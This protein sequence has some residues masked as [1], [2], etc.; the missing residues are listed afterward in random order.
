M[1]I[2]LTLD[3]NKKP[4]H[5]GTPFCFR[6][7]RLVTDSNAIVVIIQYRLGVF[8]FSWTLD[9]TIPSNVGLWDQVMALK[10]N[11]ENIAA[12]GGDPNQVINSF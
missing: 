12:F 3:R 6:P 5:T 11:R 8:G 2:C 7:T 9:E 4:G 10:W 1:I